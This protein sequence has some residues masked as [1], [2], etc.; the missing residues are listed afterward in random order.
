[1]RNSLNLK[2]CV[3]WAI[4]KVSTWMCVFRMNVSHIYKAL[5]ATQ[6]AH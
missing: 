4:V 3:Y 5:G 1:M 2:V 6:E